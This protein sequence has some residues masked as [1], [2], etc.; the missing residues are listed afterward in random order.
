M[1]EDLLKD[2]LADD[3]WTVAVRP[4]ALEDLRRRRSAHRRRTAG[5]AALGGLALVGA[6][7]AGVTLLP[8]NEVRLGTWA[9]GGVP[10]GSPAPSITPAWV[11]EHG[12]DWLLSNADADVFWAAHTRP[13]PSPGPGEGRVE[14]PA[15]L[16]PASASLLADVEAADLPPGAQ[17]RREDSVGGSPVT[18]AVHVRL[19]GGTPVEVYRVPMYGPF[20]FHQNGGDGNNAGATVEDVPG[21]SSAAAI[22]PDFGYGFVSFPGDTSEDADGVPATAHAVVVLTRG[23][24]MTTWA[25]PAAVPLDTLKDWAFAAAR[26]AGD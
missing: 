11:P 3:R 14:S 15:P 17:L 21:T 19:E 16:G 25:A 2:T 22:Y 24:T 10:E 8:S 12:R 18:T 7:V 23:G 1:I 9:A 13:R 26:H 6:T 20:A 4:G 5:A